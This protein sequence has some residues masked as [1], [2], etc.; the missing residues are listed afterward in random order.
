MDFLKLFSILE[1]HKQEQAYHAVPYK[2]SLKAQQ[3]II[4]FHKAHGEDEMPEANL[5][6][7]PSIVKHQRK[8]YLH[9][10]I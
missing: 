4:C 9:I 10:N 2:N 7:L 1:F 3:Y 5:S 6:S 8:A